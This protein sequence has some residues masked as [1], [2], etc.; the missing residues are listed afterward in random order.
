MSTLLVLGGARSGKSRYAESLAKGQ[1]IYVATA[2]ASDAE[3][4]ERIAAHRQQRGEGWETYEVPL[5]L[6]GL[7]QEIDGKGRFILIDCLTIWMSNLMLAKLDLRAE[8]EFLCDELKKA[9]ARIVLVSNEVGLGIVPANVMARAFRDEHGV[10]NQR[11]AE[12]A[13]EVVFVVSGLPIVLKKQLLK[14][15]PTKTRKSSRSRKA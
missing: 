9:K 2:E 10:L 11:I 3:M 5:D 4:A 6:P 1:K 14:A 7:L 12:V 13:D 8:V 15:R